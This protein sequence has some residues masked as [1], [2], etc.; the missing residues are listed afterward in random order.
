MD[1]DSVSVHKHAKKRTSPVS[2]PI[3]LTQEE[4]FLLRLTFNPILA[5]QK[6]EKACTYGLI[7]AGRRGLA[8]VVVAIRCAS[9]AQG[10][11]RERVLLS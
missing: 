11:F 4:N 10:Y 9:L 2:S 6:S 7:L 5:A 8:V 3:K 1:L